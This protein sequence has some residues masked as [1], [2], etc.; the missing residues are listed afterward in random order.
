ML[1]SLALLEPPFKGNAPSPA[2]A[3]F[4]RPGTLA[5]R[6]T[7]C[8]LES[9]PFMSPTEDGYGNVRQPI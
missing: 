7:S 4:S 1:K 5:H 6:V 9:Y 8:S 3:A 2:A